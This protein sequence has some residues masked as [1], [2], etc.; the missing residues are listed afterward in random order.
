VCV[1]GGGGF[2]SR[3]KS[4][5]HVTLKSKILMPFQSNTTHTSYAGSAYNELSKFTSAGPLTS[6]ISEVFGLNLEVTSLL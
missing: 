1:F 2:T 3:F 5:Y 6:N 4:A